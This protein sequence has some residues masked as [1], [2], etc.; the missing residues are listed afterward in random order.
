MKNNL[1]KNTLGNG[2]R[3]EVADGLGQVAWATKGRWLEITSKSAFGSLPGYPGLPTYLPTYM[4]YMFIYMLYT[5]TRLY[6]FPFKLHQF[7]NNFSPLPQRKRR[8]ATRCKASQAILCGIMWGSRLP[9][10]CFNQGNST[11]NSTRL[12]AT[13]INS[14][15]VAS[16]QLK[17]LGCLVGDHPHLLQKK[18]GIY[19]NDTWNTLSEHLWFI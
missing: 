14:A 8:V 10:T 11:P 12:N 5:H 9:L 7:L 16:P 4:I 13:Q 6:V 17:V 18:W 2:R 19:Q 3:K 1:G 15:R